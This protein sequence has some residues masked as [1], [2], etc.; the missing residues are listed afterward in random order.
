MRRAHS[1][2]WIVWCLF[3][4]Y[5]RCCV[6]CDQLDYPKCVRH[7]ADQPWSHDFMVSMFCR[8]ILSV[9]TVLS[10]V[11]FSFLGLP[12]PEYCVAGTRPAHLRGT[13]SNGRRRGRP[14]GCGGR[15]SPSR[16]AAC[17]FAVPVFTV[18]SYKLQEGVHRNHRRISPPVEAVGRFF[19]GAMFARR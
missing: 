15:D 2:P 17:L 9:R 4:V 3:R 10:F 13:V 16:V 8:H 1:L 12:A 6:G 11:P 7:M 19:Y 18:A 5:D 14:V